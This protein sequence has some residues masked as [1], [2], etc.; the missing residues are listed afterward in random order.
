M[1]RKELYFDRR[2]KCAAEYNIN[3]SAPS[4]HNPVTGMRTK[5][6]ITMNDR[7]TRTIRSAVAPSLACAKNTIG[8]R[9]CVAKCEGGALTP[10]VEVRKKR[11]AESRA[12][13]QT[14]ALET[15]LRV[16]ISNLLPSTRGGLPI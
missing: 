15:H 4:G 11:H 10:S 13:S 8:W 7:A 2:V 9:S 5:I 3:T 12:R 14:A 1:T 16:A 6:K